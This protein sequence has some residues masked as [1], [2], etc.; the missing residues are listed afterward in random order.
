LKKEAKNFC[1]LGVVTTPGP[2]PT[3]AKFFLLFFQKKKRLFA[4]TR[5]IIRIENV[6]LENAQISRRRIFAV[7]S[8]GQL[9]RRGAGGE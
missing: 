2:H 3:G 9:A 8:G 7:M 1:S 4:S 6:E 5:E